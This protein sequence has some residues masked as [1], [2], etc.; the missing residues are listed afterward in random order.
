MRISLSSSHSQLK[1]V[2]KIIIVVELSF[3]ESFLEVNG[4]RRENLWWLQISHRLNSISMRPGEIFIFIQLMLLFA[5]AFNS[6]KTEQESIKKTLSKI[7]RK[8][9]YLIGLFNFEILFFFSLLVYDMKCCFCRCP[10]PF[11]NSTTKVKTKFHLS[12]IDAIIN[13]KILVVF[14][15]NQSLT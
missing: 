14:V 4:W 10:L 3:E 8:K 2:K 9:E 5:F 1:N 7:S 12:W 6:D 11:E 15:S 13:G